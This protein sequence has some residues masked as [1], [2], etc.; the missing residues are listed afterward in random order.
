MTTSSARPVHGP[1]PVGLASFARF[2]RDEF[3]QSIPRRFEM[4]VRRRPERLAV[5]TREHAWSYETLNRAANRIAHALVAARGAKPEPVALVVGQGALLVA[6][7]LGVLKAGKL[8]APLD[9]ADPEPR[10]ADLVRDTRAA[11]VLAEAR[12]MRTAAAVAPPGALVLDVARA[13]SQPDEDLALPIAPDALAYVYY[14]SGSTGRPKGVVDAH[15][16]VLHNVMR[17]TNSLAISPED[18]LTLLQ[19]PS[20]SGAVSSLFGALLNGAAAFPFDVGREGADAIAPWLRARAITIYHSVPALFRRVAASRE[21]LPALRL[22]R[23]EGDRASVRDLEFYR[24]R[25]AAHAQ[26]VNG[27]GAT[28]CGLVR[29]FFVGPSTPPSARV[30]PVGYPVEDMDVRVVGADGTACGSGEVGEIVVGSRYL[31]LGYWQR[32][33]ATAAAFSRDPRDPV[34]R[35]Y[36]TGDLG[37]LRPD[38]CLEHLGRVD[39]AP[40]IRGHRV[41]IA[42]VESA[43]LALDGVA[44]AAVAPVDRHGEPGLVAYLVPSTRPAPTVSALRRGLVARLPAHAIPE[45]YV[46]L[47]ALPLTA[48]GKLDRRALPEPGVERPALDVPVIAPRSLLEIQL[49]GLW[50]ELLRIS[51]VGTHDDFFDLGGDSLLW[52]EMLQRA[53]ALL[54]RPVPSAVALESATIRRLADEMQRDAASP[55]TPTVPIQPAGRRPPLFFLHGDYLSGGLYC[56]SLAHHLDPDQ[57]FV[58][59]PPCGGDGAPT[60]RSYEAMAVRHVEDVLRFRPAGPYRLGGLCNGGLVAFEVARLLADAGQDV[61]RLLVVAALPIWVGFSWLRRIVWG[62]G[63]LVGGG[64]ERETELFEA[65]REWL[66]RLRGTPPSGRLRVLLRGMRRGAA[67]L[68]SMR[69]SSGAVGDAAEAE[70]LRR[71]LRT[72]YLRID[73]EYAPRRYAGTVTL[74]WPAED[75]IPAPAAAAWWR[76][77]AAHVDVRVVPGTHAT[78]LT[79][80]TRASATVIDRCLEG[81]TAR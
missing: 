27:L 32:E 16:N 37:R 66:L 68:R 30:V 53:E 74:L 2:E 80:E 42:D 49:V 59:L 1:Q 63:A 60:P 8:Y 48:N 64:P 69:G 22:I 20:F 25:F 51:P 10:L 47:D 3:E 67:R 26:L 5:E 52:V 4:Q 33:D 19:G 45:G 72:D 56:Q 44:H 11:V 57:P 17:Y 73:A 13:E 40:K 58:A 77:V 79:L 46:W 23:L 21:A 54:G 78:C 28:E 14:T 76:T 41:A 38:G 70:R 18:R 6:A 62:A 35:L 31:A 15:R 9:P 7:I 36:R 61:D 81:A 50:T 39:A 65:L 24:A 34:G 71:R 55:R 12:T 29:Q 43:L 75:P